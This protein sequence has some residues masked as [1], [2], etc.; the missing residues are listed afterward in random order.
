MTP[1][2]RLEILARTR[3]LIADERHWGT[4]TMMQHP[5]VDRFLMRPPRHCLMGA[6]QV[7]AN[8]GLAWTT[9]VFEVHEYLRTF[10]DPVEVAKS[11]YGLGMMTWNDQHTH[12]E[13]IALLDLAIEDSWFEL[14]PTQDEQ[15]EGDDRQDHEDSPQHE[16][17]STQ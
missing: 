11:P 3:D 9:E 15:H 4:G 12:A 14:T 1:R 10:V 5:M 17:G 13:V 6:V 2:R 7:A 8:N 16:L